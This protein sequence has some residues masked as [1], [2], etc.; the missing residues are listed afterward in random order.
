[1]RGREVIPVW[2]P[3][4][5]LH[6]VTA[7][8]LRDDDAD[9][10]LRFFDRL[11]VETVYRRF[12][13]AMPRLNERLLRRLVDVDHD[14]REALVAVCRDEII[15]LASYERR[16]DAPGT[17][18]VAVVVEDGWQRHGVGRFLMRQLGYRAQLAGVQ[19]FDATVLSTNDA[20]V[21]LARTVAPTV[22]VLFD[23]IE[24]HLLMDV[25]RRE[26]LSA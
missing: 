7:R 12:F 9:R 24:T 15:G 18:E 17:A 16:T 2:D 26:Q 11:S 3:I 8:P 22:E 10:V 1:M 23:G 14:R 21:K 6:S 19:A 5:R 25:A 20:P 4:D 13:T